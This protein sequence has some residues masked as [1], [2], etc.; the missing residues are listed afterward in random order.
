MQA[1]LVLNAD[2]WE[3]LTKTRLSRAIALVEA[4]KA[5]LHEVHEDKV[6]RYAG[7]EMLWPTVIRLVKYIRVK[8]VRKVAQWSRK[9]VLVRDGYKCAYCGGVADTNDH[10]MP[11]SRGGGSDWMNSLAACFMCNNTKAARTPEEAGMVALWQPWIPTKAQ[12]VALS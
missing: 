5:V 11:V 7:G 12:L 9:G 3:P 1:V 6:L 2:G 8:V 10:V 4:G